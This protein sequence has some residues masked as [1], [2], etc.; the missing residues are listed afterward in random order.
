MSSSMKNI[1][2]NDLTLDAI[3]NQ[4]K[5]QRL[6]QSFLSDVWKPI[7]TQ[8][9]LKHICCNDREK[10][11]NLCLQQKNG[12]LTQMFYAVF[13]GPYIQEDFE[14][15]SDEERF[16]GS[17]FT[18]SVG[19]QELSCQDLGCAVMKDSVSVGLPSAPF[20]EKM[21]YEIIETS[22]SDKKIHKILCLTQRPHTTDQ[23]FTSWREK[24]FDSEPEKTQLSPEQKEIKLRD[25]HGKDILD[26]FAQK[27][28]HSPY[29][30]KIVNSLPFAPSQKQ[31]I[32]PRQSFENGLIR[33]CLH[34]TDQGLGMVLQT[35]ARNKVQA[36]K[37]A[38]E[39]ADLY[40][41]KN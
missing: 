18:I 28:I 15:S 41:Q 36:E 35:T 1:Y 29:I 34:W 16:L 27:I 17:C 23:R 14:K 11:R 7:Q 38:R 3:D 5:G 24:F 13:I 21:E 8:T 4:V 37:I 22:N 9:K 39:L 20:W 31:F 12:I 25:D 26:S 19:E 6:L 32:V 33:I 10:I 30:I 2:F 40:D